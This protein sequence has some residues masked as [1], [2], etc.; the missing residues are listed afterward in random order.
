MEPLLILLCKRPY[1]CYLFYLP[2]LIH[3]T[4]LTPIRIPVQVG[5]NPVTKGTK[6]DN[7]YRSVG[8]YRSTATPHITSDSRGSACTLLLYKKPMKQTRMYTQ[9]SGG[10]PS[11]CGRTRS[12]VSSLALRTRKVWP[13]PPCV[14]VSLGL[15][16][17]GP[18]LQIGEASWQGA[19]PHTSRAD[20]CA[21][22]RAVS[23]PSPLW[24]QAPAQ[25]RLPT[26]PP[27][28]F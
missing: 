25:Q 15:A 12:G 21:V 16:Q 6:V 27:A 24:G 9:P 19:Q 2:L 18:T 26:V 1:L 7:N 13:G 10:D 5:G 20:T 23:L 4:V 8:H 3:E 17:A 28:I 22:R 14:S 11:F